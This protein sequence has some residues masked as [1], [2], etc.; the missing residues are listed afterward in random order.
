[1]SR[2]LKDTKPE[3]AK[4]GPGK[5]WVPPRKGPRGGKHNLIREA[6]DE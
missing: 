5:P 3:K 6:Q 4:R 2:T 1:M